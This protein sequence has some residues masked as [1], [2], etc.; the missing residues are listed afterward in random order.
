MTNYRSDSAPVGKMRHRITFEVANVTRDAITGQE[1][2]AWEVF[3]L[4]VPASMRSP[5][6][7]EV[8]FSGITEVVETTVF[9]IRY[10]ENL[11]ERMRILFDGKHY[12]ITWLQ[13]VRDGGRYID[14]WAKLVK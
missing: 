10:I 3:M 2:R 11:N 8:G 9:R 13:D 12:G 7:G 6:G 1:V 5:R 14:V 4:D